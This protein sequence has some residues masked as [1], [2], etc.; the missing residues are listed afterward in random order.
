VSDYYGGIDIIT[1][2]RV[3]PEQLFA[4]PGMYDGP[5]TCTEAT[6]CDARQKVEPAD[7]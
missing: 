3:P 2:C 6:P 5:H 7:V 1:D 4:R